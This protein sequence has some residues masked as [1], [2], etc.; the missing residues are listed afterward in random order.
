MILPWAEGGLTLGLLHPH[1]FLEYLHWF[2]G[3]I[4]GAHCQAAQSL[5][6]HAC[7]QAHVQLFCDLMDCSPTRLLY[8]W[9]FPGKNTGVGCHFLLQ[10]ISLT[11]GLN[12]CLLC[13]LHWHVGSLPLSPLGS[14]CFPE[15]PST[16][17][18]PVYI[19]VLRAIPSNPGLRSMKGE[20]GSIR[21]TNP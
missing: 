15:Q 8:P 16:W 1:G 21:H 3:F 9:D 13:L 11:Q 20:N 18:L 10:G 12:P 6:L 17:T 14:P 2:W 4:G 7:M 5:L 19:S